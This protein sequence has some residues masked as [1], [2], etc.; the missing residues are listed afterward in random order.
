MVRQAATSTSTATTPTTST[1]TSAF[2]TQNGSNGVHHHSSHQ[3]ARHSPEV[4]TWIFD[5]SFFFLLSRFV[6]SHFAFCL[7]ESQSVSPQVETLLKEAN[8]SESE[9]K[10][11]RDEASRNVQEKVTLEKKLVG[12]IPSLMH[13]FRSSDRSL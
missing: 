12:G 9:L 8:V 2:A 1:P 13:S 11:L 10:S 4:I 5:S 7:S 3:G 6:D